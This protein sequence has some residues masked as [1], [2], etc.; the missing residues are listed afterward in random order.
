MKVLPVPRLSAPRVPAVA[1]LSTRSLPALPEGLGAVAD[2]LG[3][4][5]RFLNGP[6]EPRPPSRTP[7]PTSR[8]W[9]L[10]AR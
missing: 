7:F 9:I 1:P 6:L 10:Y 3:D 2:G 4:A 5:V 8:L